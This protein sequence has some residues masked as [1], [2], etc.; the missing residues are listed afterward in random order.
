MVDELL[1]AHATVD[2]KDK[3]ERT[4]LFWAVRLE[5]RAVVK[6]LLNADANLELADK[7]GAM[8]YFAAWNGQ[9]DRICEMLT[10]KY[11]EKKIPLPTFDKVNY[12][13]FTNE[14]SATSRH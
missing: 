11:K 4:A 7:Y 3:E 5:K 2:M 14:N 13:Y 12:D 1:K 10:D 8:P 9:D 6:M